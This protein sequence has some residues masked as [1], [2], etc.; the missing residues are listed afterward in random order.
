M[1][2]AP[3]GGQGGDVSF[4]GFDQALTRNI[5]GWDRYGKPWLV[6]WVEEGMSLV[7]GDGER[8][9][10]VGPSRGPG[11]IDI[12]YAGCWS[13]IYSD[14]RPGCRELISE[15]LGIERRQLTGMLSFFLAGR[16][17]GGVYK[18]FTEPATVKPGDFVS[19]R[20]LREVSVAV[21]A[22]PDDSIP[23]WN[24]A[25]LDAKVIRDG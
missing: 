2:T 1:V 23:G 12:T 8:V 21:S 9:L 11:H 3:D 24:P 20:C 16:V 13:G 7:D 18:G 4:A 15:A 19:F 14:R 25:R 6:L 10:S 22:C 5:N 17:D